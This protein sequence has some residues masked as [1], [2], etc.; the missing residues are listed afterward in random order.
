MNPRRLSHWRLARSAALAFLLGLC[1][2]LQ[3]HAQP[4]PGGFGGF[5]GFGAGAA[6]RGRTGSGTRQYP[7]AGT[8]G[9]AVISVDPETHELVVIADEDTTK[10]IS[11]VVS[12]LDRPKPQVLIKV[13]FLEITRNDGSDIGVEGAWGKSIGNSMTGAVAH[14]FGASSVNSAVGSNLFNVYGQPVS[15]FAPIPPG[16]GLYQIFSQDYQVTLRAIATANKA[17]VLSRPSVVARNNQPAT[18]LVGQTVPLITS[19]RYDSLGNAINGITYTDV[20]I[21]LRVTPFVTPDGMVEMI[22]APEISSVSATDRVQIQNSTF[23]PVIDKR[24]ADTVV[25]APDGQT[26]IIGGLIQ[27]QKSEGESKIPFL[28][29]IPFLGNLFKRRTTANGR[30]ELLVFLTPH[31]IN[32][33]TQMAALTESERDKSRGYKTIPEQDLNEFLDTLPTKDPVTGKETPPAKKKK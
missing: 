4:G 5:G 26:V 9:D 3:L 20:G 11:Q 18:I 6:N 17:R 28:G 2:A 23:A 32:M 27:N 19:V 12:N 15:S 13:V 1:A 30:T 14:A 31:V 22:L 7:N 10:Y 24:S 8:V 21:I 16:A 25:V 33:P 29:D